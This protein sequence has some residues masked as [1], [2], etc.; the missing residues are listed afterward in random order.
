M[1]KRKQQ[2]AEHENA[3]RWLLTYADMITLLMAFFIMLYSMSQ[4][5]IRK[6]AAV[7]GS[8]RAELG[9]TGVL[10]GA[11]GVG[12]GAGSG[13]DMGMNGLAPSL[14]TDVSAQLR[15]AVEAEMKAA[16]ASQVQ[17][18]QDGSTVR[19]RMPAGSLYF[20]KGS[21]SLTPQT[22]RILLGIAHVL[23]D[24]PCGVRVEGHTC[25]LPIHTAEFPSNWELSA[26]RAS[27]TA[28]F[29]VQEGG[30]PSDCCSFMGFADRKPLVPNISE[31][32]RR[33]NRRVEL[34]LQPLAPGKSRDQAARSGAAT[35]ESQPSALPPEIDITK[36]SSTEGTTE[37]AP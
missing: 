10:E 8:V 26:A 33:R 9:G 31:I 22:K 20:E 2:H 4:L 5:D 18:T 3:E 12:S 27:N 13:V 34:I 25:N 14:G 11:Q 15:R 32:N 23:R 30:L 28:L 16:S 17:V 24:Q 6:F 19:V 35:R 21:A 29:L 1:A 37:V 36:S 7:A